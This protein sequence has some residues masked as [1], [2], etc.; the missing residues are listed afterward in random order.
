MAAPAQKSFWRRF[1][2]A[3]RWCRITALF[4]VLFSLAALIRLNRVGLPEFMKSRLLKELRARGLD[5]EFKRLRLHWYLGIVADEVNLGAAA[6]RDGPQLAVE[7]AVIKLDYWELA[8][9]HF[10]V[11]SLNLRQ[12][13]LL[14][15]VTVPPAAARSFTVEGITTQLRFLPDDRWRLDHFQAACLGADLR[16]VGNLDHASELRRWWKPRVETPASPGPALWQERLRQAMDFVEK[17][18]FAAPPE[19]RVTLQGDARDP[20]S[21]RAQ[22]NFRAPA[23]VTPWGSLT[24]LL[25]SLRL[26]QATNSE[27]TVEATLNLKID[28]GETPWGKAGLSRIN[29]HLLQSWTNPVPRQADWT[30]QLRRVA[31]PWGGARRVD[32]TAHSRPE[33]ELIRT[34]L[35]IESLEVE[36]PWGKT[37]ESRLSAQVAHS[38]TNPIPSRGSFEWRL[39]RATTRFAT[40]EQATFSGRLTPSETG[41]RPA[42]NADWGWWSRLEPFVLDWQGEATGLATRDVAVQKLSLAGT[43]RAPRVAIERLQL[44]LYGGTFEGSAQID[45]PT[46]RLDATFKSDFDLRHAM[47]LLTASG[48]HWLGQFAWDHPPRVAAQ[49]HLRLPAWTNASPAW[50]EE[51]LPSIWLTGHFQGS[52]GAFRGLNVTG[53]E[54]HFA[55]SNLVWSL[56]DLAVTRPEGRVDLAYAGNIQTHDYHWRIR[57]LIDLQSLRPLLDPPAQKVLDQL[58]V[59]APPLIEGQVWGRWFAPETIGATIRVAATNFVVRGEAAEELQANVDYTNLFVRVTGLRLRRDGRE[60]TAE[61][62]GFDVESQTI[63]FT[64]VVGNIDALAVT[65]AIGPKA[66][67][68]ILPYHFKTPPNVR[69]RGSY[70]ALHPSRA[71]LHFQVEGGPLHCLMFNAPEVSGNVDWVGDTLAITQARASAYRGHAQGNLNFDF[72]PAVGNDFNFTCDAQDLDLQLLMADINASTNRLEGAVSGRVVITSANTQDRLSWQGYGSA[73]LRDGYLWDVPIFGIFSPVL[74][75]VSPGL[76]SMRA[77]AGTANFTITNSVIRTSDLEIRAPVFRLRYDGTVDFE[78]RVNAGVQ[79]EV[80]HHAWMV[81]PIFNL[82]LAPLEKLFEYKVTGTLSDPKSS[83]MFIPKFL[84]APLH[85]FRALKELLPADPHPAPPPAAK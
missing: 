9:F 84:L 63:F 79:A 62:L 69:V 78:T 28:Q 42:S 41:V 20:A 40:A 60:V 24:N 37:D 58:R 26:F 27:P 50:S 21:A 8:R 47:P 17:S 19:F 16:V 83:P 55:Y 13:R 46:R 7:E 73:R 51:V 59:A 74:N 53:A 54:S 15:P 61:A 30:M 52:G 22:L 57:S 6:Q 36:T 81:G 64:N 72:S 56:P 43:W 66:T 48:Q 71:D 23:A 67:A 12:G 1:R 77:S 34:E 25:L 49:V 65:R 85:P 31:T 3:F 33:G 80:F 45:I 5:L 18:R 32:L 68:A 39:T 70:R 75:A 29:L 38:V 10:R 2:L 11:E 35:Q 82:A 4:L 44:G 76:G 14:V